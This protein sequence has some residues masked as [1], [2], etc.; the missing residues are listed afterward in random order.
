MRVLITI[1]FLAA[2]LAAPAVAQTIYPIDRADILAGSRFDFKVEYPGLQ[3]ADSVP[4]TINGEPYAKVLGKSADFIEREEGKDQSALVLRD[5]V[6]K[7][8]TYKVQAGA[9]TVTWN[10]FA[11]GPRKAKNVIL[12]IGDG[13]SPAHRIGARLLSKGIAQGKSLGKLAMDDMPHMAMVATAGSDSIITDSANSASAYATGHKTA[14]AAMGVYADRTANPFDDPKVEPIGKIAKRR[15]LALGIVTNTEIQDAT[16]AAM[17]SHTRR[18]NTYDQIV[19]QY[20]DVKPDVLMGGGLANFLPQKADG[21]KRKDDTDYLAKF[22]DAGYRYATTASELNAAGADAST[23]KLLGLFNLGNMDGVLDRKFLKGGTVKKFPEQP[24]LTEQVKAALAVLSK[25]PNGFFLMVESGLI[26]KYAH[27]LDMERAVY[28]TIMLDNAVRQTREWAKARGDDTLILVLADHNHP[29][30]LV[31]TINDDMTTTPNVP[32]RER[33]GVYEKAGFPNYP[34][35]DAEG[36]PDRIDVSKRIAIFSAALPDYY[37][38]FRPKLD[39]PN[40]P[41]VEN[42][43]QKIYVANEQYKDVPGAML[44]FGNL[45]AMMNASVHSG[46]DVI[47]TAEGPGSERVHGSMDNTEVFRVIAEALGLANGE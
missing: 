4:V 29:N 28:D 34:K 6:L 18:R 47:L 13:M 36:Y 9:S 33:V 45:P 8:G 5:A 1:P 3:K 26:D 44:R 43:E 24:D 15:D 31:G 25:K 2:C 42:K 7:P 30:S 11:T 32:M 12:F 19:E 39:N 35:P 17:A 37:E 14:N 46:E 23:G 10:V 21:S 41:T 40:N 20:F 38:T 16:P 22:R 27:L